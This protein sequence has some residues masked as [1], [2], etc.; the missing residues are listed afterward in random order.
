MANKWYSAKDV[1]Q[2]VK[3]SK[4]GSF[5]L[6]GFGDGDMFSF[7]VDQENVTVGT[8]AQGT[9]WAV[10]NHSGLATVNVALAASSPQYSKML[11]MANDKEVFQYAASTPYETI[12]A[13]EAII[14]KQPDVS[15]GNSAPNRSFAIKLLKSEIKPK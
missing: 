3:S 14:T 15:A 12:T 8:D 2:N 4:Q 5:T 6:T 10:I 13:P 9:P 11:K 7:S 1:Q